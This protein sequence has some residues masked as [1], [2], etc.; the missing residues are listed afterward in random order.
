MPLD[1]FT[2]R[3][4]AW[5]LCLV[6]SKQG[7]GIIDSRPMTSST[8]EILVLFRNSSSPSSFCILLLPPDAL[9]DDTS[10]TII[11]LLGLAS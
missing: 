7:L 11:S 1:G 6:P 2:I 10:S 3:G 8:T 4:L 9:K 5:G